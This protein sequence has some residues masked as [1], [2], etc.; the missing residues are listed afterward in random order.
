MNMPLPACPAAEHFGG[1]GMGERIDG[2]AAAEH[3]L[4]GLLGG[5]FAAAALFCMDEVDSTNRFL[6]A[7]AGE[8]PGEALALARVQTQGAGRRG[9]VFS[10][11]PGEA[12][13]CSVLLRG[14]FGPALPLAVGLAAC[15]ALTLLCGPGFGLK[16]PNDVVYGG[17]KLGGILCEAVP[18]GVVCGVGVNLSVKPWFFWR[19]GLWHAGSVFMAKGA[20][21][22]PEALAA[23][24]A[25]RLETVLAA[26]AHEVLAHYAARCVTLGEPVR[27]QS[28]SGVL[29]GVAGSLTPQGELV[30][31]TAK[32]RVAV[33]AGDVS[34][35]GCA[36]YV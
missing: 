22:C 29:E 32:G 21:P 28:A 27:V 19:Q 18:G 16:W 13:L 6:K 36:G 7:R 8:T 11:P 31:R 35:R 14:A 10:A 1:A 23:A 26:P 30:V 9:R 20:A 4:R 15:Q 3:R 5:R 25:G 17:R 12:M 33:R 24:L 2:A 34:V